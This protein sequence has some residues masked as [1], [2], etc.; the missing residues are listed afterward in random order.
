[1]VDE[2]R[3]DE[4][5]LAR[6]TRQERRARRLAKEKARIPQHGKGLVKVYR[7]VVGRRARGAG[8]SRKSG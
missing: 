5:R 1:M 4:H 8:S 2:D 6:K 3:V 7:D